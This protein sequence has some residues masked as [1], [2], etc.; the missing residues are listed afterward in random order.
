MGGALNIKLP[1]QAII[2]LSPIFCNAPGFN[3]VLMHLQLSA[4]PLGSAWVD[5][6]LS[7][8]NHLDYQ[9]YAS[10][11]GPILLSQANP[12]NGNITDPVNLQ[13]QL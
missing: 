10:P 11:S 5:I 8:E 1:G 2:P 4:I 13:K 12:S 6:Q 9:S 3:M 7:I